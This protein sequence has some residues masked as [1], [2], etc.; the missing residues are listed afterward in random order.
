MFMRTKDQKKI[1]EK[2]MISLVKTAIAIC[3]LCMWST[4]AAA[5][6]VDDMKWAPVP[7]GH[8][9]GKDNGELSEDAIAGKTAGNEFH[10]VGNDCGI[11]HSPVGKANETVFSMAGT[12]YKD[13][14]GREPLKGAEIILQDV[15][16]NVIS[17]TTNDAGNFFTY[18]PIASD[19]QAWDETKTEAENRE[20]PQTWRYKAWVKNGDLVT[21]MVTLAPVGGSSGSTTARMSCG[22]HHAPMNSRGALLASGF[23]TLDAYPATGVSFKKHV[24]PILKNRCKSCHLPA[25][26]NPWVEYPKGTKIAYGGEVDLSAYIK[27]MN[28]EQGIMDLVNTANPDASELLT[29]PM[30][31]SQHAGGAS[32]R[33]TNDADYRA[34]RQWIAEGA[35]NN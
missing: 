8:Q 6:T 30:L 17:M 13:R 28:S 31:G 9:V 22:M 10:M 2:K 12:L 11:C 3:S 21:A 23:P 18:T 4:F 7:S 14:A 33:N 34:I 35:K 15:E 16:G 32:W 1:V 5:F 25:S 26:A 20:N 27:D 29:I 24:M 19:P